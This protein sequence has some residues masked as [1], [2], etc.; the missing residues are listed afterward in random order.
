MPVAMRKNKLKAS[1]QPGKPKKKRYAGAAVR[2]R[3][4]VVPRKRVLV[5]LTGFV[6]KFKDSVEVDAGI[7]VIPSKHHD[8]F[9]FDQISSNFPYLGLLRCIA[10]AG[11]H[12]VTEKGRWKK[13]CESH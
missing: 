5:Q 10:L 2:V 12:G 13:F 7:H 3:K 4:R 9:F 11:G 1:S 6:V 8:N